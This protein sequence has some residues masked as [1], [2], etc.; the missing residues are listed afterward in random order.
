VSELE[1]WSHP[2]VAARRRRGWSQQKLAALLRA[3]GLG[4][5]RKSVTRWERDVVPDS[6]A[7]A[8]LRGVFGVA[9]ETAQRLGW[10]K[11]LPTGRIAAVTDSWDHQGAV[12]AL[13][14][15][16][17][18]VLVDRRG[19]LVLTGSELI[20]PVYEWR[21]NPGPW[22]AYQDDGGRQVSVALV[23]DLEQLV[24]IR[25]RMDDEHGGEPLLEMLHADLRFVVDLLKHRSYNGDIGRR[26][27]AV[28]GEVAQIAGWLASDSARHA[29]AQQYSLAALR[30]SAAVGDRALGVNV[31]GQ[32]GVQAL[33]AGRISDATQLMN[34][35]VTE[36]RATPA[37][38]QAMASARAGRAHAKAGNA[39]ATRQALNDADRSLSLAVDGDTPTWAYWIDQT[40]ITEWAGQ[41]L[42][43]LGDY[44]AATREL[45]AALEAYGDSYPRDRASL[46]GQ[47]AT[48]QLRTGNIEAGCES[49]RTAVDLLAGQV[50]SARALTVLKGFRQELST[51]EST[52]PAREFAEYSSARLG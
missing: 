42:F 15:V 26:L 38:V 7:Q 36:A 33:W 27:Y 19:F 40:R 32:M 13:S 20:L 17:E 34:V 41:S 4:T 49:G 50:H 18:V 12:S 52:G 44:P 14:D 43:D 16:V 51:Y 31:V 23:E 11:W 35:A 8:A 28:A 5:T 30:A 2:L 1:E 47:I 46:L 45:A 37:V 39:P 10:P 9:P 21:L 29:A 3:R 22:A 48:A 6:A 25:R 24:S